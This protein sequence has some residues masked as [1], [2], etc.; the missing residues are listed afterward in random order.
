[1]RSTNYSLQCYIHANNSFLPTNPPIMK[2]VS[3]PYCHSYSDIYKPFIC[4]E[5][6]TSTLAIAYLHC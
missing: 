2:L 1:M 6:G 4:M 3:R 5:D